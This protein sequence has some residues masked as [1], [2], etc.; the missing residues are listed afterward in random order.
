VMGWNRRW[1]FPIMILIVMPMFAFQMTRTAHAMFSARPRPQRSPRRDP[2][3][4]GDDRDEG[5]DRDDDRAL[6]TPRQRDA[7]GDIS[8]EAHERRL[9][10]LLKHERLPD[11]R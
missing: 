9:A 10:P 11:R 5:Q 3:A 4:V 6:G 1:V 8:A 2:R 7:H